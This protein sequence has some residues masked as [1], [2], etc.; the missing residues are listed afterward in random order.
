MV[1]FGF[2][3]L[4]VAEIAALVAVAD[5]IGVFQAVGLL[6]VVSLCG[7]WLVRRAG[8]GVWRRA[9]ER[10]ALGGAPDREVLD[11]VLL[12][13][14]GLLICVPGFITD[15]IGILLL[16]PPVRAVVRRRASRRAADSLLFRFGGPEGPSARGRPSRWFG[17]GPGGVVDAA[18]HR[19]PAGAPDAPTQADPDREPPEIPGPEGR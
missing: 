5:R 10:L 16:L 2:L 4:V 17:G 1:L 9:Q 8:F 11:G 6:I 19:P 7:P 13:A 18:S 12:L 15:A 3:L 14:A